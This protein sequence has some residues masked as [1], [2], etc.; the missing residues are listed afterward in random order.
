VFAAVAA[1]AILGALAG[2]TMV[3]DSLTGVRLKADGPTS[4]IKDCNDF[5][6]GEYD[7]EQKLHQSNVETCQTLEQPDK[8]TCLDAESARHEAAMMSLSDAKTECQNNCHRQ[9]GGI[10]G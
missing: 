3:G 5:Y 4:C 2:C 10:A 7:L 9:G 8:G 1:L 6:K